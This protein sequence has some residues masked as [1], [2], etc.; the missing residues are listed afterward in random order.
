MSA[1]ERIIRRLKEVHLFSNLR[2]PQLRAL[3]GI[4]QRVEYG[5]GFTIYRQ[6]DPGHQ[7]FILEEGALHVTRVDSEGRASEVQRM[8][9]GA[10]FGETALLL[11]DVCDATVETLRKTTL[12]Y[13]DKEDF[14]SLLE[15]DPEI[16]GALRMRPDVAERRQYPYFSWLEEGELP[17]KVLHKHPAVLVT[18]L[19]TPGFIGFVLLVAGVV[20]RAQWGTWALIVGLVLTL[21]PLL[22]GLYLYID[23][24]N[25]IY[26][27]TNRRVSHW[28]RIGLIREHF[29]AAPLREIQNIAQVQI[30]PLARIWQYGDLIMEMTGEGGQVVFRSIPHLEQVREIIS[31]QIERTRAGARAYERAAIH[32]TMRRHFVEEEE[33]EEEREATKEAEETEKSGC[34]TLL[35]HL[36]KFFLPPTWHR[37]GETITWRKHWVALIK[38]AGP[39]LLIFVLLTILVLVLIVASADMGFAKGLLLPYAVCLLILVPWFIWQFDDWQNDFYRV[40]ST[41]LICVERLPFLLREERLESRLDRITNVRFEQTVVGKLLRYGDVSVETAGLVGDF[42]LRFVG[43]PQAVQAE[44]FSHMAAFERR[45]QQQEAERRRAELLDWF[46]VYDEIRSAQSSSPDQEESD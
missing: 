3:A 46:S 20:A 1:A 31:E 8:D 26:I 5:P 44:I 42:Q 10:A 22:A 29:S 39:P 35:P 43:R 25:D 33:E 11:G 13:I 45:L 30:G 4:V 34:L 15:Q 36:F 41:R 6:G 2:R 40:T 19:L 21:L 32:R 37:E 18:N 38:P 17:V 27:V 24:R 9:P 7:Y 28:E 12:L 23:W 14:D 16:E